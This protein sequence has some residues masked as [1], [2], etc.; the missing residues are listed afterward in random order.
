MLAAGGPGQLVNVHGVWRLY[1]GAYDAPTFSFTQDDLH[2]EIEIED[3]AG[4]EDRFNQ[5]SAI[6]I[7]AAIDYTEQ[8]TIMRS[9]A[10][11][12]TQDAGKKLPKTVP[13]RAITD[14]YRAQRVAERMLRLARQMRKA[15]F[16]FGRQGMR[17]AAWETFNYSDTALG[18]TNRVF[19]CTKREIVRNETG[20]VI[21]KITAVACTSSVDVD[22]VTA[23]YTSGTS[24]TNSVQSEPPDAPTSLAATTG[25]GYIEFTWSLGA[26]W[27]QNGITELWEYT[28]NT[29]F[30]SATK[31]WEGRGTRVVIKKNDQTT[32]YYWVRVATIGGQTSSTE[33]SGNGLAGVAYFP[34][35][36]TPVTDTPADGSVAY[37][38]VTQPQVEISGISSHITYTSPAAIATRCVVNYSGQAN[39]SNTTSGAATGY[40]SIQVI[41]QVNGS[42]VFTRDFRLEAQ[43]HASDAWGTLA[44]SKTFDVPAGQVID[45]FM[46][47]GRTFST[48]GASPA[49]TIY[50]R[51][52]QLEIIP[53][54]Q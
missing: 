44:G 41:V 28:A 25:N 8:T 11:Y 29:P 45:V 4:D 39:V 23:D 51:G 34:V 22:L 50:W 40:A 43:L 26:F 13:L 10:A 21:C 14:Q 17:I 46:N 42:T 12:V 15:T 36:A 30:A 24:V 9:N 3:T 27:L 20:G 19:R 7:D 32:R 31:I 49:Q 38:A 52:A 47:V 5:L 16:P 2:G 18:W 1:A 33:P 37:L 6:Y 54:K 53:T 48:G 35:M